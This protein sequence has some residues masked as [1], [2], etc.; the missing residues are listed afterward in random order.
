MA[1]A[2]LKPRHLQHSGSEG[3]GGGFEPAGLVIEVM[4]IVIHEG[5]EPDFVTHLFDPYLLPGEYGAEINFL[6]IEAD[7]SARGHGHGLVVER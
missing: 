6:P 7:T 2:A 4:E 5:D 1:T 3:I